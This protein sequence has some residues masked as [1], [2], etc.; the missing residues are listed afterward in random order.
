MTTSDGEVYTVTQIVHNPT[1]ALDTGSSS[2]DS[3]T[4]TF[5]SNK[6]AVA[7]T[8][9]VVGLVV[10]GLILALSLLCFR[11]RRRQRLDR[12][13]TAAAMAAPAGATGRPPLDEDKG[14]NPSSGPQTSESYPSTANQ[15][16]MGQY[17]G[18]G[19]TY[20]DP[21]GGYD[22]YAAAAAG[23]G[24]TGG[25]ETMQPGGQGY[26][27]DPH[28]PPEQYSVPEQYSDAPTHSGEAYSDVPL[29]EEGQHY[30]FDPSQA[31]AYAPEGE[32][33]GDA[34]GG[35]SGTEGSVGT[36]QHERENPL[37]VSVGSV[38]EVK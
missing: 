19:A 25:Y 38:T 31:H 13:V 14:Y 22:P 7:G 26:Y 3:S 34:Y 29:N 35:Y 20:G 15:T 17:D 1:G 16:P 30:Y 18:Y 10:I 2:S 33:Y 9:V 27:Y 32:G 5:F 11:R 37:H 21:H 12:E 8:F 23:Y 4:N 6:G 36:P 24:A 28:A